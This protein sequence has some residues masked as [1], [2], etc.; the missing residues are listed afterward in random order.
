MYHLKTITFFFRILTF[1]FQKIRILRK[2]IMGELCFG[3]D[4]AQKLIFG[5]ATIHI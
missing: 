4:W 5:P 3:P 2:I 1:D